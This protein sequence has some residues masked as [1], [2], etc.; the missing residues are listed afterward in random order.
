MKCLVQELSV[1]TRSLH[2]S[3]HRAKLVSC[4]AF[5]IT[6]SQAAW[7]TGPVH[8]LSLCRRFLR[9]LEQLHVPKLVRQDLGGGRKEF[10][11]REAEC[12]RDI[13]DTDKFLS[14]Y[15]ESSPSN[16]LP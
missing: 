2:L 16:L 3:H 11:L 1:V 12:F 13:E 15:L 6:A 9:G 7:V 10:C 8:G 14:R 5:Q 4:L